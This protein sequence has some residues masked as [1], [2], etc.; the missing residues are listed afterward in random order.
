MTQTTF[1]KFKHE[2]TLETSLVIPNMKYIHFSLIT[3]KSR[4][5]E[6]IS[7]QKKILIQLNFLKFTLC[8]SHKRGGLFLDF[9][10]W[11]IVK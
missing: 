1:L 9:V 11:L 10:L 7:I 5:S 8:C 6:L 2:L 4:L 3:I